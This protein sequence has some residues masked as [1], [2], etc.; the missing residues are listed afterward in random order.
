M[1]RSFFVLTNHA[2]LN[3]LD[4]GLPKKHSAMLNLNRSSGLWQEK[5]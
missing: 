1:P 3:N 4:R 2:C 5:F